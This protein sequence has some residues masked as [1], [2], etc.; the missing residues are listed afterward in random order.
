MKNY[1][2]AQRVRHALAAAE[3]MK[4]PNG[5][6]CAR[7]A[8]L[9]AGYDVQFD[10]DLEFQVRWLGAGCQV[11][12]VPRRLCALYA[13]TAATEELL[14]DFRWPWPAIVVD[15]SESGLGFDHIELNA[16]LSGGAGGELI[17]VSIDCTDEGETALHWFGTPEALLGAAFG[18][19]ECDRVFG[20]AARI[21]LGA[22]LALTNPADRA[23]ALRRSRAKH[24]RKPSEKF[25]PV[26]KYRLVD[27]VRVSD[28][29]LTEHIR[30]Y[31]RHGSSSPMVQTMVAGHY[32]WQAHGPRNALRKHIWV[33]P[34]IRGKEHETMVVRPHLLGC[35]ASN[36]ADAEPLASA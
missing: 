4:D 5:L 3:L 23:E 16:Q 2:L 26:T 33:A 19:A 12:E 17:S 34:Y 25:L 7:K 10:L 14:S 24:R 11:I 31:V 32:K 6:A 8:V 1:S 29:D 35:A 13:A 36:E 27:R 18:D 28:P 21:A 9:E 30:D 22:C 15:C 20:V